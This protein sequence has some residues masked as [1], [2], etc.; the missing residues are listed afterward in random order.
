MKKLNTRL[1]KSRMNDNGW[2]MHD[3]AAYTNTSLST[4]HNWLRG[5]VP[6]PDKLSIICKK[7]AIKKDNIIDS[8]WTET[9][10][11]K[12]GEYFVRTKK[13]GVIIAHYSLRYNRWTLYNDSEKGIDVI[14][15]QQII[16]PV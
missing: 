4:A 8:G 12:K 11:A 10:P 15:W 16:Y 2:T 3:L 1:V 14:E 7:L 6:K 9:R 5:T 13:N